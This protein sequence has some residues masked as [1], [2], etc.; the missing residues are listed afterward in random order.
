M[1][2]SGDSDVTVRRFGPDLNRHGP[3]LR[4]P[5][6]PDPRWTL[7]HEISAGQAMLA[8]CPRRDTHLAYMIDIALT[9]EFSLAAGGAMSGGN[10]VIRLSTALAVLGVAAVAAVASYEHAY[11]RAGAR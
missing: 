3:D 9:T 8:M 1:L 5:A 7:S 2:P 11:D 10:R 6:Q 4:K